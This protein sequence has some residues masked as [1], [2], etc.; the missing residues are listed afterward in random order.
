MNE[1]KLHS[2]DWKFG[3]KNVV[4]WSPIS[5]PAYVRDKSKMGVSNFGVLAQIWDV[6]TN[7]KI[8]GN[9]FF[10]LYKEKGIHLLGLLW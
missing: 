10:N 1:V 5:P 7:L 2:T 6:G 3:G 8:Q 4:E 9:R